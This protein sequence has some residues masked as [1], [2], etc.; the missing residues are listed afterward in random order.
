MIYQ[1]YKF[2]VNSKVVILCN[3]PGKLDE[4]L[5]PS[6][7]F[8]I[9]KY[10]SLEQLNSLLDILKDQQNDSQLVVFDKEVEKLKSDFLSLFKCIEAAGGLVQNIHDEVLV[11]FR[12]GS[13]DLPKG[14]LDDGETLEQAAIREVQE[15]TGLIEL[16]LGN[17][18]QILPYDNPATYH[19]YQY[20]K[21]EAMKISYWYRMKY[22]GTSEP[23]P[24]A[25]EDIE[26]VKWVKIKDLPNYYN[27]MY[28]S[29]IDVLEAVFG[30]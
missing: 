27:N 13:W 1:K 23:I 30:D 24:Q 19:S 5:N 4:I 8:I 14:K 2:F 21:E 11:I 12:Q 25:E 10:E 3:N 9:K 7:N 17:P 20:K 29:I 15:E 16:E 18:I 26:I 6:T 28:E 22:L